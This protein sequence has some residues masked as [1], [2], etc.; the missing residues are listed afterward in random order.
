[1]NID[2]EWI[3]RRFLP[4]TIHGIGAAITR[5]D[6]QARQHIVATTHRLIDNV[7]TRY[8]ANSQA[9]RAW[10][11]ARMILVVMVMLGLYVLLTTI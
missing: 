8:G 2:V 1:M 3:Y 6:R 4:R 7:A 11:T 9:A 5:I 10:T